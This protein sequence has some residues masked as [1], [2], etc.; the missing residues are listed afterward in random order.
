MLSSQTVV[1]KCEVD[2]I[3]NGRS[4]QE[5]EQPIPGSNTSTL[6]TASSYNE[7]CSNSS[8]AG[9]D[10]RLFTGQEIVQNVLYSSRENVDI[11]HEVFRQV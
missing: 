5:T 7:N 2:L 1:E 4:A 10:E 8:S 3:E 9:S 6:S 11:V